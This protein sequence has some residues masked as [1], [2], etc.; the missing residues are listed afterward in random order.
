MAAGGLSP[1][2][3]TGQLA[4]LFFIFIVILFQLPLA[5]LSLFFVVRLNALGSQMD[6]VT[7]NGCA[8]CHGL[9]GQSAARE[10]RHV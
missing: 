2:C 4:C 8:S 10:G 1:G 6:V 7:A 5:F 3:S 9:I